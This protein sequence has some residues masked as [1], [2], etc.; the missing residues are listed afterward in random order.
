[1]GVGD[2]EFGRGVGD[3]TSLV[4]KGVLGRVD[5]NDLE[6]LDVVRVIPADD[7]GD[8][9]LAVDARV[10]PE[11]DQHHP[12]V[13]RLQVDRSPTRRVQ[14]FGDPFDV[15]C[16]AAVFEFG[17]AVGAVRQRVVLVVDQVAQIEL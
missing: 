16:S 4:F 6:S 1:D 15:R 12:A 13:Q 14:P 5:A 2:P 9:A 3:I 10:S 8:V 7:V 11:V 17:R